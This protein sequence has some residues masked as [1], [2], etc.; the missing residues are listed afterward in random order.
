MAPPA[1]TVVFDSVLPS[2]TTFSPIPG[3]IAADTSSSGNV[4]FVLNED[5][6]Y[7]HAVIISNS[8]SILACVVAVVMYILLRRK[9]ARL[10]TRTSLKIS[11]AMACT[12]FLFH[13]GP[14]VQNHCSALNAYTSISF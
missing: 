5:Q 6:V 7:Y 8:I 11:V 3:S 4:T 13:V 9:N 12:D 2:S 10:M 14:F 1:S